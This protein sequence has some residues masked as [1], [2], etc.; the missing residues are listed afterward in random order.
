[1]RILLL[2]FAL[3]TS[4]VLN[5][6][7]Y[8]WVGGAGNWSDLSHWSDCS[9]CAGN[10]FVQVPQ[11]YNDVVI[12]ENSGFASVLPTTNR[13]ITLNTGGANVTCKDLTVNINTT[14]FRFSGT[15]RM[16]IYG[17]VNL[18]QVYTI[19]TLWTGE[20]HLFGNGVHNHSFN[21]IRLYNK[22]IIEPTNG[23]HNFL[24]YANTNTTVINV[25]DNGTVNFDGSLC[26]VVTEA[27]S[28]TTNFNTLLK[29]HTGIT[30]ATSLTVK[31]NA[32]V[33]LTNGSYITTVNLQNTATLNASNSNHSWTTMKALNNTTYNLNISNAT[34]N[35]KSWLFNFN[36]G[37]L[38]TS[39]S[40]IN[41]STI[42]GVFAAG[43]YAYNNVNFN[44]YVLLRHSEV[45][46]IIGNNNASFNSLII[47]RGIR[48]VH[49]VNYTI[50]ENGLLR[51]ENA[52]TYNGLELSSGRTNFNIL[53]NAQVEL[54]GNCEQRLLIKNVDFNFNN[55]S[56]TALVA[57]HIHIQNTTAIGAYMPYHLGTNSYAT[58]YTNCTGWTDGS[59]VDI[60]L[61]K[62]G[63]YLRWVGPIPSNTTNINT[64]AK[65]YN[66][67]NW[68]NGDLHPNAMPGSGLGGECPPTL[69]DSVYF[70]INSYVLV[71]SPYIETKSM[72]WEGE[73]AFANTNFI[74]NYALLEIFGSL[75]WS[76]EMDLKY[77][78]VIK[79]RTWEPLH[80]IKSNNQQFQYKVHIQTLEPTSTYQLLDAFRS[81]DSDAFFVFELIHGHFH[82]NHQTVTT[83]NF[84]AYNSHNTRTLTLTNSD[85]YI[86]GRNVTSTVYCMRLDNASNNLTINAGTSHIHISFLG[87][88]ATTSMRVLMGRGHAFHKFSLYGDRP[89][90]DN[91]A[92]TDLNYYYLLDFH[93]GG[94]LNGAIATKD[95]I[96]IFKSHSLNENAVYNFT[97]YTSSVTA[98]VLIDSA[99][100]YGNANL[101]TKI[102]YYQYVFLNRGHIYAISNSTN[103]YQILKPTAHLQAIG[104]CDKNITISTGYFSASTPQHVEYCIIASNRIV[105]GATFTY[106]NSVVTGTTTGWTGVAGTPRNLYWFNKTAG[107]NSGSWGDGSNWSLADGYMLDSDGGNDPSIGNCPPTRIDNVFFTN[108]SFDSD[109]DSVLIDIAP[110][111][112]EVFNMTW[113]NTNYTATL[114]SNSNSNKLNI[115]G[116]FEL[117]A[118]MNYQFQGIVQCLGTNGTFTI[119]TN[120]ISLLRQIIFNGTNGIWNLLDALSVNNI[121]TTNTEYAIALNVG[122]LNTNNH[123]ITTSSFS[124][125]GTGARALYLGTS[126]VYVTAGRNTPLYFQ[127]SNLTLSAAES[128]F[129]LTANYDN[130]NFTAAL[131]ANAVYNLVNITTGRG[132]I[133]GDNVSIK[134]AKFNKGGWLTTNNATIQKLESNATPSSTQLIINGA[135]NTIDSAILKNN[136]VFQTNNYYTQLLELTPART[137]TFHADKVQHLANAATFL[138]NGT[139]GNEIFF[140]SNLTGQQSYIRKDSGQV[141]LDFIY[142]RDL[143]A[144]GNGLSTE[145]ACNNIYCDILESSSYNPSTAS[146]GRAI[147]QVGANANDQ[148]NNA[149][150]NFDPYP[151]TP[152]LNLMPN[153]VSLVCINETYQAT[154]SI[155]GALPIDIQYSISNGTNTYYIDSL[156]ISPISGS[157]ST[158]NPYIW[159]VELMPFPDTKTF[160]KAE[161]ISGLRC[162]NI[163]T[164]GIGE[165]EV[166]VFP[167]LLSVHLIDFEAKCDN[168]NALISWAMDSNRD[169]EFFVLESSNNGISFESLYTTNFNPEQFR[170]EYLD[171]ENTKTYYR[172]AMHHFDGQITYSNIQERSCQITPFNKGLNLY[173]NPANKMVNLDYHALN[174]GFVNMHII[175]ALGQVIY[176]QSKASFEGNNKHTISTEDWANG[177]YILRLYHSNGTLESTTFVINK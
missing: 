100:F 94:Q 49:N 101:N 55:N 96:H 13:T 108:N 130:S 43:G 77:N 174:E 155:V 135:N 109:L 85:F 34:I 67:D 98:Q 156:D 165:N 62:T 64:Y 58:P 173:P 9:G 32:I 177:V 142:M 171:K 86:T 69:Y 111:T 24:D 33:N 110:A 125:T 145:S 126:K 152:A 164:L 120:G 10:A 11:S 163:T 37:N 46:S 54:I 162:G 132:Q 40:T 99:L 84:D 47:K 159:T 121:V 59:T 91:I 113:T 170:Y 26:S 75:Q 16:D 27:Q 146:S 21:Y 107:P 90:I 60:N 153:N 92:A 118:I 161:R 80:T 57:D 141:C 88:V 22:W 167:C 18:V 128:E 65:W 15:T 175:N 119:K 44:Q 116:S 93:N 53:D 168:N 73:G 104:T 66:P 81:F 3:C 42:D 117:S 1:M 39:N 4:L 52:G 23:V 158:T 48:N 148:G 56:S 147:F 89:Q 70:P 150:W 35:A 6:Q 79:L 29:N 133:K 41:I 95:S 28:G 31:N 36:S 131:Y 83:R 123:T 105:G 134:H 5:A 129:Y 68:A 139:G 143:W 12:D 166:G 45:D 112:A 19:Q 14:Y 76:A 61:P 103:Y 172:L 122:R 144:I 7:T 25:G 17:N 8:Y 124:C 149:G 102:T 2:L 30:P 63:R 71:D 136:T 20:V 154:F 137:Y 157:G 115:H 151:P 169:I 97:F 140:N 87:D 38:N 114:Y 138:G 50:N 82:T 74:N 106:A 127:G 72:I 176:T 160:I 78:G 51:I